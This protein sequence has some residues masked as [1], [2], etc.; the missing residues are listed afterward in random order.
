MDFDTVMTLE[1]PAESDVARSG[2]SP[3]TT[4][5]AAAPAP[6]PFARRLIGDSP[7]MQRVRTLIGQV[8]A[9]DTN[10]LITGESGTG[11]E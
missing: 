11:K 2:A 10:V 8:A 7:S 9:F 3:R 6:A 4:P 1:P 5:V